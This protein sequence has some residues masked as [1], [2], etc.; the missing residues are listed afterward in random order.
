MKSGHDLEFSFKETFSVQSFWGG[1]VGSFIGKTG[2]LICMNFKTEIYN[3]LNSNIA[4][5]FTVTD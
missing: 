1:M 5:C 3:I 2:K 4:S